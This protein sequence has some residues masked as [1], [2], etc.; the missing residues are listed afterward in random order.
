[1]KRNQYSTTLEPGVLPPGYPVLQPE[2][3]GA[4][5][6]GSGEVSRVNRVQSD[7]EVPGGVLYPEDSS[8]PA[9]PTGETQRVL[10][11]YYGCKYT[12]RSDAIYQ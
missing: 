10:Q 2:R 3:P 8:H 11:D 9:A 6:G 1:M 4:V 12:S 7:N 5:Y